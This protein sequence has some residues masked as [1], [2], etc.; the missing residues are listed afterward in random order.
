VPADPG[1]EFDRWL[2]SGRA[3]TAIIRPDRAVMQAGQN[4]QAICDAMPSFS[5]VHGTPADTQGG[6]R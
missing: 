4:I 3:N 2:R 5:A 6:H 1:G